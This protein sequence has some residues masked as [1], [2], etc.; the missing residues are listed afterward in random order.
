[1]E[2]ANH[3]VLDIAKFLQESRQDALDKVKNLSAED[4]KTLLT[5]L[6]ENNEPPGF[7]QHVQARNY[8]GPAFVQT[9]KKPQ[10]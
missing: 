8:L 2:A 7:W 1:M 5:W 4:A 6:V 3:P 9:I 10:D